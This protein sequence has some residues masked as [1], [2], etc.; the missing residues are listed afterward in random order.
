[1]AMSENNDAKIAIDTLTRRFFAAFTN[2]DG[3]HPDVA[4]LRRLLIPRALIVKNVGA[5][6]EYFTVDDFIAPREKL[7]TDG[8]LADFSEEEL[9]ERTDIFGNIAQRFCAY[10][11]SGVLSGAP[12][13]T[14]GMK[15]LQFVHTP[16]GWKIAAVTWDDEA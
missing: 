6:P 12:F 2:K 14:R 1:M 8:T 7:L 4:S 11:K 15:T 13:A 3:A 9:S 5:I 10:R 16:E